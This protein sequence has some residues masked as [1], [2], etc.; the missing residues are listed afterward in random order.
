MPSCH[1][2]NSLVMDF[3]RNRQTH[4][5]LVVWAGHQT[6]GRGQMGNTWEDAEGKNLLISI[7]FKP[8][9]VPVIAQFQLT[10][11]VSLA[12][13]DT[14]SAYLPANPEI[15]WPN[16]ILYF[17]QKVCGILI[18]NT[19][20]GGQIENSIV[21]IGVNVNQRDFSLAKATSL[22]EICQ[23]DFKIEEIAEFLLINLE[24]RYLELKAGKIK[25]LQETYHSKL[26]QKDEWHNYE[27]SGRVFAGKL[28]GVSSDG[29][30]KM[31]LERGLEKEFIFKQISFL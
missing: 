31:E 18:E 6:A 13:Y 12:V 28:I 15:K 25:S 7:L 16:D 19:I 9:F 24:K 8:I 21:G 20:S 22:A 30:L 2:T 26:Y 17:G 3:V 11:M 23:Q 10:M 1:S 27:E 5:G 4:E 14:L 29:K